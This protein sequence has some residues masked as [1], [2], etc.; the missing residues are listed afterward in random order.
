MKPK[1]KPIHFFDLDN[2]LWKVD[3][4]VWVI[5]KESSEKPIL[6]IDNFEINRILAGF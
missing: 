5:D 1:I 4:K 6:K 3:T 2:V